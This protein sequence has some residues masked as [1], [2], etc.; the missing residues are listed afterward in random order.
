[1]ATGY[2]VRPSQL[3]ELETELAKWNLDE[4]C[5]S[6][7]R[8]IENNLNN[9]KDAFYGFR[10]SGTTAQGYRSAKTRAIKKVKIKPDGTW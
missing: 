10:K 3:F 9:N 5:L 1:M 2:G 7:G 4:A 8:R 6:I